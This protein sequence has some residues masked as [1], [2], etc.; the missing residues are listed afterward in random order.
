M[1][2][3]LAD[4]IGQVFDVRAVG[5]A[6]AM[7][8]EIPESDAELGAGLHQA[9]QAVAGVAAE[10]GA[11]AA[12]ELAPSDVGADVVFRAV[13]VQGNVGAFQ[14][15]QQFGLVGPVIAQGAGQ[16]KIGWPTRAREMA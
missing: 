16:A 10:I 5:H 12:A 3:P 6:E 13:G 2:G 9:E 15:A 11:G 14:H 8:E 1:S 4:E 7:A